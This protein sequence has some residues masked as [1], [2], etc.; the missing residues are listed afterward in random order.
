MA[1]DKIIKYV[2]RTK[3]KGR[4]YYYFDTGQTDDAGKKVW[5]RLPAPT[6]RSFHATYAAMLGHRSRR[7]NLT[8]QLTLA[9][10]IDLY[11]ASDKFAKTA[12]ST[13]RLYRLYQGVLSDQLGTAPAQLVERKDIVLLLDK[14]A[15][16]PGAA[17]MVQRA[18]GAA[19][20]WARRRGHVTN[21]PFADIAPMDTGEHEPWPDEALQAALASKDELVR[22]SVHLLYF[23]A[24]RIG[25]VAAMKWRD[26]QDGS[27]VVTQRKTGKVLTI[28]IHAD[29]AKELA[30]HP[31]SLS[32]IIPG[33]PG[34][35]KNNRIRLAIQAVCSE[36]GIDVVPHGLR[37]NAV[38]MLLESECSIA[39]T[40]A[41][42]GQSLRMI[43]HYAKGRSQ[44]KLGKAA[45]LKWEAKKP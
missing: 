12:T 9:K 10:M 28:P 21:D 11:Q 44:K 30:R 23:T 17:N 20:A 13:Q 33:A 41:I 32:T 35:G 38:I 2:K 15:D 5:S 7:A 39:E 3:A 19:Y 43:E 1:M 31:R 14:M 34:E 40:A 37:K 22:L 24:Q 18:G 42:S 8:Q 29:L 4:F 25:D 45:M 27:I 16:R 6:D 26:I 36:L